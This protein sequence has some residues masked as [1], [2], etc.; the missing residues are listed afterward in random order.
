[1]TD[2]D[3]GESLYFDENAVSDLLFR[4][5][6]DGRWIVDGKLVEGT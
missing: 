2:D 6:S 1:M 5:D 3:T 4:P